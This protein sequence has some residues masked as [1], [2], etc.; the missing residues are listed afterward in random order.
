MIRLHA[1]LL[2]LSAAAFAAPALA[3]TQVD[4][5]ERPVSHGASI[6]L[7]DLFDGAGPAAAVVVGQAAPAGG[8]TV[9]ESGRVQMAALRA[10]LSW[11]NPQGR[12]RIA[13]DA[14]DA[15]RTPSDAARAAHAA[16]SHGRGGVLAYAR[17]LNP[18]EVV[19][20]SDLV[21]SDDA[22][23][24]GDA[25][26]DADQVIGKAARRPLREGAAVGGRDLSSP[27][28]IARG[29]MVDVA[30]EEGG[31]SLVLQA[32]AQGDAAVGDSVTLVNVASHKTLEAVASAPGKA[33]VGAAADALKTAAVSGL[34]LASR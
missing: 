15:P 9:L 22:V 2:G 33:V 24:P 1:L 30:F 11:A 16:H 14:T 26:S 23:S 18:G 21:W 32:K 20:A 5:R 17:N 31:V 7:G 8:Q 27:K 19:Q 28:V 12:R 6:T 29:E 25:P 10:G 13:V 34:A 4:L 3:S